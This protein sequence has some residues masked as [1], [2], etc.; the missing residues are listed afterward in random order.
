[1][2]REEA[3]EKYK[4]HIDRNVLGLFDCGYDVID[5]V[6]DEFENRTCENCMYRKDENTTQWCRKIEIVVSHNFGCNHFGRKD[7][8]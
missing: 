3:K 7:N 8:G 1:M 2:N 6:F 4:K 5:H